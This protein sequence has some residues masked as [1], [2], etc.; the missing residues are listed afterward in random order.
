MKV[1]FNTILTQL[2]FVTI[3]TL[4]TG[5]YTED[6]GPLQEVEKE[7]TVVDFDRLEMGD[8]FEITVEQGNLFEVH[9]SGDRRNIDD[10]EVKKEGTT[11]VIRYKQNRSR[12]HNTNIKIKMPLLLSATFSG[13]SNSTIEGFAE[14]NDLDIHLSG[15][16]TCQLDVDALRVDAVLSGAS[17]LYM[18]GIGDE[19]HADLSGASVLKAFSYPVTHATVQA[20]G[21]SDSHVM[22][23]NHLDA[24]ASGASVIIYRGNPAVDSETSG[25]STVRKD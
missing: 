1:K 16:S 3:A 2:A 9:T 10:L 25:S 19:I 22:V 4:F 13:A 7:F 20:S 14:L 12:N 23:S 15:A 8:A 21:A 24:R 18:S 5:C 6:P 11:L 17:Y